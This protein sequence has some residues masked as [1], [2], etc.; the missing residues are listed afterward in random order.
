MSSAPARAIQRRLRIAAAAQLEEL[1]HPGLEDAL[2]RASLAARI[3]CL[4][5]ELIDIL[6]LGRL[7][8]AHAHQAVAD[9]LV[10]T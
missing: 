6:Q 8:L 4:L 2:E 9:D 1:A 7:G 3:R 5:V 10:D